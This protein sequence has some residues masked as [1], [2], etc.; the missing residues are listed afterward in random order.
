MPDFIPL[1]VGVWPVLFGVFAFVAII[2]FIEFVVR[3]WKNA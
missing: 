2:K 1:L 3:R